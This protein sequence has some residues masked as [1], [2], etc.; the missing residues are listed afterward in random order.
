MKAK[1]S[2]IKI[3]RPENI[4]GPYLFN[5]INDNKTIREWK[6]Q[7]KIQFNL[8]SHKNSKETRTMCTKSRNI[9]IK[10]GNK[11]DEIID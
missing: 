6:I 8:I 2:K 11:T 5:M 9:E 10:E 7:L 1:E 4:L 3:Y